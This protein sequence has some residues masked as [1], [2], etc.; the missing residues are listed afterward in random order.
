MNTEKNICES[1][2]SKSGTSTWPK[3]THWICED[4]KVNMR[5]KT[6][7]ATK[8]ELRTITYADVIDLPN[9]KQ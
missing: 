3:S 7:T 1:C 4:C 8:L 6:I 5:I 2:A 9:K